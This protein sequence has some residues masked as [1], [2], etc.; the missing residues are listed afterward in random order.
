MGNEQEKNAND[1]NHFIDVH[2]G[3]KESIINVNQTLDEINN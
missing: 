3:L 1:M 2:I